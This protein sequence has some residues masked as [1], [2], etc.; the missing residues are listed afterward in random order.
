MVDVRKRI[1]VE[2]QELQK[3]VAGHQEAVV[4]EQR[5]DVVN[6]IIAAAAQIVVVTPKWTEFERPQVGIEVFFAGRKENPL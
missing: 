5:G 4:V 1:V 3:V 2:I 6:Q